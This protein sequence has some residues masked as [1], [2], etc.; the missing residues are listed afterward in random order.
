MHATSIHIKSIYLRF[1]EN[2]KKAREILNWYYTNDRCIIAYGVSHDHV[3]EFPQGSEERR[4][5]ESNFS[6]GH[7]QIYVVDGM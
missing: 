2:W 7:G 5:G 4:L 1:E 6:P 3:G